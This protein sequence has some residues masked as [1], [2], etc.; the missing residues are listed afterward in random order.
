VTESTSDFLERGPCPD[1]GSSDACAIYDDGHTHCF[2]CNR[3]RQG[4]KVIETERPARRESRPFEPVEHTIESL[5]ERGISRQTCEKYG[6]GKNGDKHVMPFHDEKG[7]LVAFKIRNPDKTFAWFGDVKAATL[8]GQRLWSN[9]KA[10]G[11]ARQIVVTEGELDALSLAQAYG[12]KWPVVSIKNGASGARKELA[13][14]LTWLEGFEKVVLMFDMD[15][16]GQKAARE[17]AELFTPGKCAVAS[18]PL[19]DANEMLQAGRT[20]ELVNAAWEAAPFRPEGIVA[21]IDLIERVLQPP[22]PST[23]YPWAGLNSVLRGMRLG[24]IVTIC[25]GTGGGKTQLTRELT[26]SL[27]E[28]GDQV[29][30]IALE[31]SV[32]RAALAQVSLQVG[33]RLHDPSVRATVGDEAIRAAAEVALKGVHF[34]EHFGSVETDI[35]LPRIR[36]MAKALGVKWVVLDHISIM[37]SGNATEGDERKRIDELMTKLRTLVEEL[38]IG[39]I[40]VSHLR[41]AS[42]TPHEEGGRISM[43]DLRGSG[44]IKQVSDNI[45]AAERNQQAEDPRE[46]NMTLLRVLKCRLFGETGPAGFLAYDAENGRIRETDAPEPVGDGPTD[47]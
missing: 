27:R 16:P 35:I 23:P 13:A 41:K 37:I 17:C 40:I 22:P 5:T 7:K 46:R 2:S 10:S 34:F 26:F 18:L 31:E 9:R 28:R 20:E 45:I 47:F 14:Q 19:K 32:V 1:C 8:F 44:A 4:A 24:E 42:G 29:G 3:T 38:Q 30:V 39:V 6:Y 11:P 33:K 36:Y 15:E 43:D 25:G 12:L 21:G